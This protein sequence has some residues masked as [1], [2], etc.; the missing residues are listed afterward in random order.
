MGDSWDKGDGEK[1]TKGRDG[2]QI[3]ETSST[4]EKKKSG[5]ST[6]V[7][8]AQCRIEITSAVKDCQDFD[9]VV[10]RPIEDEIIAKAVRHGINPDTG[11]MGQR[12]FPSS[13]DA[14]HIGEAFDGILGYFQDRSAGANLSLAMKAKCSIRSR[15]TWGFLTMRRL[16]YSCDVRRV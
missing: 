6:P 13:P 14:G 4:R 10:Q 11:Q 16:I 12:R 15:S 8:R 9:P 5:D 1:N 7:S 3:G 2:T